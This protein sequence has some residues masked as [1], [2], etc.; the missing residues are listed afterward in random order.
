[1]N[2]ITKRNPKGKHTA[3]NRAENRVGDNAGN[4]AGNRAGDKKRRKHAART[5]KTEEIDCLHLNSEDFSH[6]FSDDGGLEDDIRHFEYRFEGRTLHITSNSGVFSKNRIDRASDLLIRTV[7]EEE[8]NAASRAGCTIRDAAPRAGCTDSNTA[9]GI[10]DGS[11]DDDGIGKGIEDAI[12]DGCD[13]AFR[14]ADLGTGYGIILLSLL[15]LPETENATGVGFE[16]S[17]RALRLARINAKKNGLKDR[18]Q[19]EVGDLRTKCAE[20]FHFDL[21]VTNPPIRAGKDVLYSFY[22]FA[23]Q[24]L[25]REGRFYLVISK[26]QGAASSKEYLK[27]LFAE[28]E[29]IKKDSEFRVIRCS[30]ARCSDVRRSDRKR[31]DMRDECGGES[32]CCGKEEH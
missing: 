20:S 4:R 11:E 29:M 1:M 17:R 13:K 26:N 21:I 16:V 19:F 15:S 23:Q 2:R 30:G 18:V 14:I 3:G 32:V 6:Y 24:A 31:V 12:K 8:R 27:E 25:N 22:R 10:E 5:E 28:V 7:I 9:G